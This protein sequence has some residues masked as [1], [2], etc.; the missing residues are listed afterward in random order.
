MSRGASCSHHHGARGPVIVVRLG[1]WPSHVCFCLQSM[2]ILK[3]LLINEQCIFTGLGLGVGNTKVGCHGLNS[4]DCQQL[5]S[6][7]LL[8]RPV[9]RV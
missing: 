2:Y 7:A 6:A 9:S 4:A 3:E 5:V 1:T 8:T